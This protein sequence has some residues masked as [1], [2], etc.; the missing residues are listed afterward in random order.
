MRPNRLC[1]A[2]SQTVSADPQPASSGTAPPPRSSPK[3]TDRPRRWS[4]ALDGRTTTCFVA[5]IIL[6]IAVCIVA[7]R[8][9]DSFAETAARVAQTHQV[10]AEVGELQRTLIDVMAAR[11]SYITSFEQR[12]LDNLNRAANRAQEH[13]RILERLTADNSQQH[14]NIAELQRAL[15]GP[16]ARA[17]EIRANPGTVTQTPATPAPSRS[18]STSDELLA[19]L[20][21]IN[22]EEDT[23]LQ[24]RQKQ[25]QHDFEVA[26][27][28]VPIGTSASVVLLTIALFLLNRE[29]GDRKRAQANVVESERRYRM[30]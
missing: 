24:G 23:R 21:R 22:A 19:L 7:Y 4:W 15:S 17:A 5:G 12:H 18:Q 6:L 25:A 30:L 20:T 27:T 2:M 9:L 29:A 13:L 10:K 3:V 14:Q 11:R 1:A 26:V 8:A 28:V 16:L